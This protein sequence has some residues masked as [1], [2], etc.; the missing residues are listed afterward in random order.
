MAA[1]QP[2]VLSGTYTLA[3]LPPAASYALNFAWVTDQGAPRLY[4]SD[5]TNWWQANKRTE[6]YSGTTD[7]SGNWTVVFPIAFPSTPNIQPVLV[8]PSNAA[9]FTLTASSAS[10]F[11]VN[12]GIRASLTVLGISLLSFA[13]TPVSGQ[14][15]N[16]LVAAV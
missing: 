11:T 13:V 1:P 5:G 14:A 16:A 8:N 6:T 2:I 12:V 10:G 15:V 3:G 7:A 9:V 4:Y